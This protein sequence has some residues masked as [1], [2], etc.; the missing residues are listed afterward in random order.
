ME[1][2]NTWNN[3]KA[4][5]KTIHR[6][7]I[8]VIA[9]FT[10]GHTA[11]SAGPVIV[12]QN[13]Y[14]CFEAE[15]VTPDGEWLI[16]TDN[17]EHDFIDGFTGDGC[18]HF[19]GNSETN[20]Q[21]NSPITYTVR[22]SNPGNYYLKIRGLEAPLESGAGDKANDCYAK[23]VGQSDYLGIF[24]KHVL[25][26]SSYQWNWKVKAE[27]GHHNFK[28]PVYNLSTGEH[29]FKIAGRSKN[30]FIDR[31]VMYKD[32]S[33]TE[34]KD[35][36][37]TPSPIDYGG[38]PIVSISS[39]ANNSS[40]LAGEDI[41]IEAD[42]RDSD[43]SINKVEFYEGN[44]KLGEDNSAPYNYTWSNVP[45]GSYTF[46]AKAIDNENNTSTTSTS[47]EV[48]DMSNILFIP[49]EEGNESHGMAEI[50][51]SYA[52]SNK[53]IYGTTGNTSAPASGDS[54]STYNINLPS[55][56]KWYAWGRFSYPDDQNNSFWI[57]IDG[58]TAQRFGNGQTTYNQYHWEGYMDQGGVDL[59]SLTA[60]NHT[61][62]IWSREPHADNLLDVICLTS[63]PGYTPSDEDEALNDIT[64]IPGSKHSAYP[65][66]LHPN[67]ASHKI[68][69]FCK[70]NISNLVIINAQGIPV[71]EKSTSL[72]D[73]Q[74]LDVSELSAGCYFVRITRYNGSNEV[75]PFIKQ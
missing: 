56:G 26:G 6:F 69:I 45:A 57:A 54:K 67:P 65:S 44:N 42:A 3:F 15:V 38:N 8:A 23:M 62:T 34:A 19:T 2:Q 47:I 75:V 74:Q 72:S 12:E 32:I 33:E 18:I 7:C 70:G 39:P 20:G 64:V 30:F 11:F 59:G 16:H 63:N 28:W 61:I 73:N 27:D 29:E 40:M 53:S 46:K 22:I 24:T 58:G 36:S 43:G 60:G 50:N 13:G 5:L 48:I 14:I 1:K 9:I 51:D 49:A 55:S 35:L 21:V 68:N 10:V 37:L 31:I 41:T 52:V 66:Y 4:I 17:K 25:L 71:L